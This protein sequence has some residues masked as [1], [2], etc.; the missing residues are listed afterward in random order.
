MWQR[1]LRVVK[2][3]WQSDDAASQ[4]L[5]PAARARLTEAVAQSETQH[6][7]EIRIYIESAL[8]NSY[9]WQDI[10]VAE[11]VH[12]RAL[13][14]FGKLKVWDTE[15]NNGVLIYLLLVERRLEIVADRGLNR[16]VPPN[17][18]VN[19]SARMSAAFKSSTPEAGLHMA[20][21]EVNRLL[22]TYFPITSQQDNPDELPNEPILN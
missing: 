9:L 4:W 21:Q 1:F 18:W 19:L 11:M 5:P 14:L 10:P 22:A 20:L 2:H 13:S 15:H 3:R 7:G 8:P 16:Q 12:Q 17:T 6:S